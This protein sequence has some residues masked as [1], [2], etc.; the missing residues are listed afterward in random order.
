MV[1]HCKYR[2]VIFTNFVYTPAGAPAVII[3]IWVIVK[4][5]LQN[6]SCW[7]PEKNSSSDYEYIYI[8]PVLLVLVVS[9]VFCVKLGISLYDNRIH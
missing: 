6:N 9:V 3:L 7:L 8:V 2:H 4:L 5:R 1:S